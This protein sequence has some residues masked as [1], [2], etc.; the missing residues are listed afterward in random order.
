MPHHIRLEEDEELYMD[1]WV[2]EDMYATECD[3]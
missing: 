2:A 3:K 1:I